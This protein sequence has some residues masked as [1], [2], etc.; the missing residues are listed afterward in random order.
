[1]A[2]GTHDIP[3]RRSAFT[4]TE[5]ITAVV[6]LGVAVPSM[7]WGVREAHAHRANRVLASRAH[8]LAVEKL[9]DVIADRHS[10]T[11]GYGYLQAANYPA[12]AAVAGFTGFSRGVG[13]F[14]TGS[15]LTTAGS[16]YMRVTVT[17]GY[18]DATGAARSLALVTELT[19][20]TP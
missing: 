18:T 11:R 14:E 1:M 10:G 8:W 20:Y 9:E 3:N 12:E 13:F 15:N 17:V 2:R 6:I 16:G 7:L 5:A 19:D 4:L